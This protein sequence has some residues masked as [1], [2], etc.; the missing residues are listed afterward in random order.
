[1][2]AS[3]TFSQGK[4]KTICGQPLTPASPICIK[5]AQQ[6]IKVVTVIWA[7]TAWTVVQASQETKYTNNICNGIVTEALVSSN[8]RKPKQPLINY[9]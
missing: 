1:M 4:P 7:W 3:P 9:C 6:Q 8:L 5:M 2:R